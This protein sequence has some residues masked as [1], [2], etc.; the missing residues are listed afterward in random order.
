MLFDGSGTCL[1]LGAMFQSLAK[2]LQN[3][4]VAL[5][6][7][8][9]SQRELT[10]VFGSWNGNFVDPDQKTW[11]SMQDIDSSAVFGYLFQQLG[12]AAYQVFLAMEPSKR[13]KLFSRMS[14]D[15]FEFYEGSRAQYMYQR[16]Q[17]IQTVS[18]YFK[19][20]REKHCSYLEICAT[21]FPWKE[22]FR[23]KARSLGFRFPYFLADLSRPVTIEV[24]AEGSFEIGLYAD[25]LPVEAEQLAS[26]FLGRVPGTL[27]IPLSAEPAVVTLPEPPWMLVFGRGVEQVKVNGR[28]LQPWLS[29]CDRYRILGIG[30]VEALMNMS[31]GASAFNLRIEAA[32]GWCAAVLPINAFALAS[33]LVDIKADAFEVYG[34]VAQ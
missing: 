7:S 11:A 19:Q 29:E 24:P 16:E 22:E 8:H 26:I 3:E 1:L 9:T 23:N 17:S 25:N 6:Y 12:V 4:D 33:G 20:A 10:H 34:Q 13:E 31:A 5:H 30:E 15:Y 32:A 21:D 28:S 2:N 14:L 18:D 27:N